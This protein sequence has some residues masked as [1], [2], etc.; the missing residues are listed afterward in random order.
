[1]LLIIYLIEMTYI[2]IKKENTMNNQSL[3]RINEPK[4][5]DALPDEECLTIIPPVASAPLFEF[6][7]QRLYKEGYKISSRVLRHRFQVVDE[8]GQLSDLINNQ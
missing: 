3:E 4:L 1:M 7:R 8:D 5:T 2:T 6:H